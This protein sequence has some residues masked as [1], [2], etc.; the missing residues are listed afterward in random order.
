MEWNSPTELRGDWPHGKLGFELESSLP[1]FARALRRLGEDEVARTQYFTSFNL[2]KRYTYWVERP[3]RGLAG[4]EGN[5]DK[6]RNIAYEAS[7][8]LGALDEPAVLAFSFRVRAG[9]SYSGFARKGSASAKSHAALAA[10]EMAAWKEFI[11]GIPE[12]RSADPDLERLYYTSWYVLKSNRVRF[13]DDRFPFPFTS[14]NKLHYYNQFF[15]DSAFQSLAWLWYDSAGPAE[16][17]LKNFTANQWRNGMIPYELFLYPVNGREWMDG[18]A[19]TA[20]MTQPPVIGIALAE[21]YR[22]FGH[23]DYLEHFYDSLLRYEEWLTLYRDLGKRGLSCYMNIWETGWD[24]SPRL[25]ASERNRVLDPAIESPD[26]NA[27]AYRLRGEI[28]E[29]ARELGRSAPSRV[30][31]RMEQ[32]K[33]AMNGLMYDAT[34]GFYHDLVAGSAERIPVKTAAGL[35]PLVTDIPDAARRERLVREYV[36][37]EKEFLSGCPL[38]SV[39]RSEPSYDPI[40][41]WRGANWPQVTWSILYGIAESDPSVA[42][43]VLD[44]FLATTKRNSNCYE[45]YDAETGQGVGMPFQ[46]WGALYTDFILRFVAGISPAEGGFRF[47]PIS[48]AF[49]EFSVTGLRLGGMVISVARA[50]EGWK[51]DFGES[52]AIELERALPFR[53]ARTERKAGIIR[54]TFDEGAARTELALSPGSAG[55][56]LAFL[57]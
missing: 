27:F 23:R 31:E 38:P 10:R 9:A 8:D 11:A 43:E 6:G 47:H 50:G 48:N 56:E 33:A 16:D 12:F 52:G 25:D 57:G 4:A 54:L 45:Y 7:V 37:N 14:V 30:A 21:I 39:S 40:D 17:E 2:K 46:G 34:D 5:A 41:F 32:T 51:L 15:W 42:A 28:I 35:L 53:A 20:G 29:I 36:A 55:L 3:S 18:D 19:K 26:F 22:K 1:F 49:R 44:R 13:D 24:N